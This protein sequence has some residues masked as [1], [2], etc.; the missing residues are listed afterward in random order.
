M[1]CWGWPMR[2]VQVCGGKN[3]IGE[4]MSKRKIAADT[5]R[6][7]ADFI[8]EDAKQHGD[9]MGLNHLK[10]NDGTG[11]GERMRTT[12]GWLEERDDTE[13]KQSGQTCYWKE[14]CEEKDLT[15]W[16]DEPPHVTNTI[17]DARAERVDKQLAKA[18]A[19]TQ[20]FLLEASTIANNVTAKLE[21]YDPTFEDISR[22]AQ[23][24]A[25]AYCDDR[26]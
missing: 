25:K 7:L 8:V 18:S 4:G 11:L 21:D 17:D 16:P 19:I 22:V 2:F 13:M 1:A 3:W 15:A 6:E 5:L 12:A 26:N 14:E 23:I 24:L 20:R 10:V 9:F